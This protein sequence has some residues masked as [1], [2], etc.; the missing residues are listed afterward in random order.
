MSPNPPSLKMSRGL[1]QG[2]K[3]ND[4]QGAPRRIHLM[5][6]CRSGLLLLWPGPA[7]A[8]KPKF[9]QLSSGEL[10]QWRAADTW[11]CPVLP[12]PYQPCGRPQP[13]NM[14]QVKH[15]NIHLKCAQCPHYPVEL[16][17]QAVRRFAKVSIVSYSRPSLMII[18][19]ASQFHV[20]LSYGQCLFSIVS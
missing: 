2:N 4:Q 12:A 15:D 10:S 16:E 18:A 20:Y 19:L 9:C 3:K 8:A 7:A 11:P 17:T 5:E 6:L 13:E 1:Q 14:H